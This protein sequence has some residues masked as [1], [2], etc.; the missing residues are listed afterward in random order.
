V[1]PLE[2]GPLLGGTI[3]EEVGEAVAAEEGDHGMHWM[4]R[5]GYGRGGGND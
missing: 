2:Q 5:A 3:L 4:S 1:K